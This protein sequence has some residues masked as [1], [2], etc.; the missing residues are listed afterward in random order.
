M[1]REVGMKYSKYSD[2]MMNTYLC[3][4]S[5]G[6]GSIVTGKHVYALPVVGEPHPDGA[7]PA[8]RDDCVALVVPV[9]PLHVLRTCAERKLR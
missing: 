8:A 1:I 6:N 4:D 7:V 3:K 2:V 9:G 5:A